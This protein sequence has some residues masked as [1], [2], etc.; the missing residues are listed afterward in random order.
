[1]F[2]CFSGDQQVNKNHL[3]GLNVLPVLQINMQP[4]GM[5]YFE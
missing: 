4:Q 5:A 1:M 2:S 3:Y